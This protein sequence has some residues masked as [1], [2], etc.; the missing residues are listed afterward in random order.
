MKIEYRQTSHVETVVLLSHQRPQDKIRVELDLTE[1][2]ITSSETE[3]TY[4]EIKEYIFEQHD[5]KIS[6]LYIAQ[7]KEKHGLKE[8]EN[9]N[10][11]KSKDTKQP[12]CPAEK[13]KLI[14]EALKHFKMI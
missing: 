10:K 7:V 3:A 12:Q 4:Q 14:E 11:A 5:V 8:R 6:S 9:Y 1:M 2:D 13:E